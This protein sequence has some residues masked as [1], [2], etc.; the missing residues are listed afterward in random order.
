MDE[1]A[2]HLRL[3]SWLTGLITSF[4]MTSPIEFNYGNS[5]V[6]TVRASLSLKTFTQSK[7]VLFLALWWTRIPLSNTSRQQNDNRVCRF[8]FISN[9]LMGQKPFLSCGGNDR[10]CCVNSVVSIRVCNS[11]LLPGSM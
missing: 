11:D 3:L 7:D 6:S 10:N 1:K 4:T 2:E 8:M 5:K 9:C